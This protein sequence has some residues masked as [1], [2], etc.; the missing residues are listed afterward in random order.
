[1]SL[2]GLDDAAVLGAYQSALAEGGGWYA[3]IFPS[4][5]RLVSMA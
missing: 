4:P 1:M 5:R 3:A 2:N